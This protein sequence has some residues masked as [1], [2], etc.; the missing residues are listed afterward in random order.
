MTHRIKPEIDDR[1]GHTHA[2]SAR[3]TAWDDE[4]LLDHHIEETLDAL[5]DLD[6]VRGHGRI[7]MFSA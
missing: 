7:D 6:L 1:P 4:A 2:D 3:A 5:S